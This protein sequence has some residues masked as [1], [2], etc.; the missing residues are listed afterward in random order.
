MTTFNVPD[1]SCG[2]CT[3]AIEKAVKTADAGAVL[4]FDLE[5]RTVNVTSQL[6]EEALAKILEDEGY[7]SSRVA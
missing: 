5:A 2:H 1:M 7:P 3:G 6:Q 4:S